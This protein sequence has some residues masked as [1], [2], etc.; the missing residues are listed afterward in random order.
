MSEDACSKEHQ[1]KGQEKEAKCLFS[2]LT[3]P[4]M[5]TNKQMRRHLVAQLFAASSDSGADIPAWRQ[6]PTSL[7]P[8]FFP[9]WSVRAALRNDATS[10]L[11][12]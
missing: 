4:G 6:L 10:S 12:E 7:S 9:D 8:P 11:I 2:D 1:A 5:N 3:A